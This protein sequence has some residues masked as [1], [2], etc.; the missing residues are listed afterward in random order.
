MQLLLQAGAQAG[1][2]ELES[3]AGSGQLGAVQL[4]LE[5]GIKDTEDKALFS[6]ALSGS[7]PVVHLLLSQATTATPAAAHEGQAVSDI[8]V[9][10]A[11]CASAGTGKLEVV[12]QLLSYQPQDSCGSS[13]GGS[14]TTTT[15]NNN[16]SSAVSKAALNKALIIASGTGQGE[17]THP[18]FG[19]HE[20][21]WPQY[22]KPRT[23]SHP[24]IVEALIQRGADVNAEGGA[25]LEAAVR[26]QNWDL[27]ELLLSKGADPNASGGEALTVAISK[28]H[29]GMASRLVEK[30]AH[31]SEQQK[32]GWQEVQDAED[33][34]SQEYLLAGHAGIAWDMSMS[35]ED[36]YEDEYGDDY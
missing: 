21:Y 35:E 33:A 18:H 34:F 5:H 30:G 7:W 10:V 4:L 32:L 16:T 23:D 13:G 27:L 8:R 9:S 11:L 15:N 31:P 14:S 17:F 22:C 20:R 25:A 29:L 3:A 6:A 24:S 26:V 2:A 28:Q 36:C 19:W 1:L 12:Q